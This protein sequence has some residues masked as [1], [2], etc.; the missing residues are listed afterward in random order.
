MSRPDLTKVPEWYHRY[1]NLVEEDDLITAI[2]NQTVSFNSFL[3]SIPEEKINYR[4]AEGKWTVKEV[5]QHI[6]DS[7]RVFSYRALRF[8]RKDNTPLPGFD[9]NDF[10]KNA[11]TDS[12][13]WN[14]L[15]AEFN[16]VRLSTEILFKSF[17]DEQIES[18]GIANDNSIIVKAIGFIIAGHAIHHANVLKVRYL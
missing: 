15:V 5:L 2:C 14:D 13:K 12:R 8:A 6:I 1:I 16:A 4:Y 11:K 10:A 7:E 18:M 17:D 3:D 9:E